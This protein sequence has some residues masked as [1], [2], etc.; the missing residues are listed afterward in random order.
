MMTFS[1]DEPRSDCI[2]EQPGRE[3][4][5]PLPSASVII[6]TKNRREDLEVAVKSLLEQTVLP[7]ELIIIDQSPVAD[8]KDAVADLYTAAAAEVRAHVNLVY[9][10]DPAIAG[11]AVARNH[12]IERANSE[13]LVF[14][15]DDVVLEPDFLERMLRVYLDEPEVSGVSGVVTNYRRPPLLRH[16]FSVVFKLGP[17]HDER[18]PIYW[19]ADRLRHSPP[20]RVAKFGAGGMSLRRTVLAGARFDTT[21]KG[22]PGGED[23]DLCCRLAGHL[24]VI[25]PAVRYV[26]E[27]TPRNRAREY[28]LQAEV[29]KE[30]YV[31]KR[32]WGSTM[33]S[34]L[35]FAWLNIGYGLAGALAVAR[36]RSLDPWRALRTG[37]RQAKIL[38]TSAPVA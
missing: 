21:L 24:L 37:I 28:W 26:H 9:V 1:T 7:E 38:V 25:A 6:P 31:Y 13:I 8:S 5:R 36:K 14:L 4:S 30:H 33:Y 11:S 18:Q 35:C 32:N 17:F 15:D 2:K 20:I 16:L 3:A 10:H 23:V 27:R 29:R 22:V 12:G 34:R 19:N